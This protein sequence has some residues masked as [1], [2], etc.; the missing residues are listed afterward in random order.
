[1]GRERI[2][3]ASR[4]AIA[5]SIHLS[6]GFATRHWR[7]ILE[8]AASRYPRETRQETAHD[9]H[10]WLPHCIL[11]PSVGDNAW[12]RTAPVHR[13]SAWRSPWAGF[14][15]CFAVHSPRIDIG[16][17]RGCRRWRCELRGLQRH[18]PVLE[19]FFNTSIAAGVLGT[20]IEV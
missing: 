7:P 2:V 4:S 9:P 1:M 11:G 18:D 10:H 3:K 16:S 14:G 6:P 13:L 19:T 15:F 17:S 20:L 8:G 5:G 12:R